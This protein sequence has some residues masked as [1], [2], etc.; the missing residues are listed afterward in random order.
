MDPVYQTQ[1]EYVIEEGKP[2]VCFASIEGFAF[3]AIKVEM[4]DVNKDE[5]SFIVVFGMSNGSSC[6]VSDCFVSSEVCQSF[7]DLNTCQALLQVF[8][9]LF[10]VLSKQ[11][12]GFGLGFFETFEFKVVKG[13]VARHGEF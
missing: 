4:P 1:D 7:L 8:M 6:F 11:G 9:A 3:G 10:E 5:V 2:G 12:G 13:I